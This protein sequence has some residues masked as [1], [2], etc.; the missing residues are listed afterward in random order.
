MWIN[1]AEPEGGGKGVQALNHMM[2]TRISCFTESQTVLHFMWLYYKKFNIW[3]I[4]TVWKTF[5]YLYVD[6]NSYTEAAV[7]CLMY[8]KSPSKF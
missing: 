3:N 4:L 8:K 5:M 2:A 7:Y 6:E 1:L